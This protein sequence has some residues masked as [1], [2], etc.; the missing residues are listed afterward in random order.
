MYLGCT[1]QPHVR[2]RKISTYTVYM[3]ENGG[4][5]GT[6]PIQRTNP[7]ESSKMKQISKN[8]FTPKNC[9]PFVKKIPLVQEIS[10][11]CYRFTFNL[12]ATSPL[13]ILSKLP[14]IHSVLVSFYPFFPAT[15][16]VFCSLSLGLG[17]F[18]FQVTV[19]HRTNEMLALHTL[20]M[21]TY[22]L[23]VSV[24]FHTRMRHVR[25]SQTICRFRVSYF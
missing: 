25:V 22:V 9:P 18:V 1:C 11:T 6:G 23:K 7:A 5:D 3:E 20:S 24:K 2:D 21:S 15:L 4:Y 10:I 12:T 16:Q 17:G 8:V 13:T 19:T 14:I